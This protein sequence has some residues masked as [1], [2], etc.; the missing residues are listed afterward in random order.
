MKLLSDPLGGLLLYNGTM[1]QY[2][3]N[4][5]FFQR[6]RYIFSKPPIRSSSPIHTSA[7]GSKNNDV[8]S[9][10]SGADTTYMPDSNANNSSPSHWSGFIYKDS[11][12]DGM[13]LFYILTYIH[14][15]SSSYMYSYTA[16]HSYISTYSYIYLYIYILI[17]IHTYIKYIT[18][19]HT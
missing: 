4:G 7:S 11:D 8:L 9:Y 17:H 5:H 6:E 2:S 16:I 18:Y 12:R 1:N 19:I 13:I 14:T 3:S 15:Y 10:F